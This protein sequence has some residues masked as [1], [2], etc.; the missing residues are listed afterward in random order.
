MHGDDG[1]AGRGVATDGGDDATGDP[2]TDGEGAT[3]EANMRKF[4]TSSN[5]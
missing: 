3:F 1:S 2:R 5:N 4:I